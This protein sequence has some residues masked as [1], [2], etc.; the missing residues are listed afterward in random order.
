VSDLQV[1]GV[2]RGPWQLHFRLAEGQQELSQMVF[3]KSRI[4]S[5]IRGKRKKSTGAV[6]SNHR[7]WLSRLSVADLLAKHL[8][9]T[10]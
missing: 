5:E 1:T 8:R 4:N 10:L 3:L 6:Q 9:Q 7:C 2:I